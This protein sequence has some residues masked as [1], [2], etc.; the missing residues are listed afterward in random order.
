MLAFIQ[1]IGNLITGVIG[2]VIHGIQTFLK[3]IL[4]VP[5]ALAF[6][7]GVVATLPAFI[8]VFIVVSI[9]VSAVLFIIHMG[10]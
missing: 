7:V 3:I 6:I 5:V 8:Q 4:M 10:A 2:F 1:S 9:S